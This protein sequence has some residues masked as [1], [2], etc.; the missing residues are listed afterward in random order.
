MEIV[1]FTM[2][3][4]KL[5]IISR[6]FCRTGCTARRLYTTKKTGAFGYLFGRR[7]WLR[8]DASQKKRTYKSGKFHYLR[9]DRC[10]PGRYLE[11]KLLEFSW[12]PASYRGF[13]FNGICAVCG[14]TCT[15]EVT[16][17]CIRVGPWFSLSFLCRRI[18]RFTVLFSSSQ[19]PFV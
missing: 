9:V 15:R 14:G 8:L 12:S 3:P 1:R 17:H 18:Q 6:V 2:T 10:V 7:I 16:G 11:S 5:W 19:L 13:I 4:H